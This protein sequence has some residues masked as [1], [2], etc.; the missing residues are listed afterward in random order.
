ML[1][2]YRLCG[3]TDYTHYAVCVCLLLCDYVF[4]VEH[5]QAIEAALMTTVSLCNY[6]ITLISNRVTEI[7]V[8]HSVTLIKFDAT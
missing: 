1:P 6:E 7:S 4:R 8:Q 3:F 2:R 5:S